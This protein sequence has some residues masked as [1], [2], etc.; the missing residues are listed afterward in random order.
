MSNTHQNAA[1]LADEEAGL[2]A[3]R[4]TESNKLFHK[5]N[6]SFSAKHDLEGTKDTTR[7]ISEVNSN[8]IQKSSYGI[9]AIEAYTPNFAISA[10]TLD[11]QQIFAKRDQGQETIAVWDSQE[12]SISMA[13]NAVT[14]LLEKHISDPYSIGR[15][16]VGTE[17]NVDMAKSI[18][19]YLMDLFPPDHV[20]MEGVDNIN[21]SYGA[22]AALLN[23][24]SWCRETGGFGI[25]V[26][27]DTADMDLNDSAW[28][29]ASA[30]AM[31]V[32][33]NPW[34]E[35]HPERT[36]YFKNT[37]DFLLPRHASQITPLINT[38]D[39][40]NHYIDALAACIKSMDKKFSI[41]SRRFDAFIF[42]GGLCATFM[43]LVER[44]LMR[45]NSSPEHWDA[46]FEHARSFATQIGGQYNSSLYVNL[47]SLLHGNSEI[48]QDATLNKIGMFAYGAGSTAT[49]MRATIHPD[50]SHNID[51]ATMIHQRKRVSFATL[52]T[53]V[54]SHEKNDG[55]KFLARNK[56]IYYRDTSISQVQTSRRVYYRESTTETLVP[57]LADL[58]STNAIT[59]V[60]KTPN[61]S[62]T[63]RSNVRLAV[64]SDMDSILK[65]MHSRSD[66]M[67]PR[68]SEFLVESIKAETAVLRTD[69]VPAPDN[70]SDFF[71]DVLL[72]DEE[73]IRTFIWDEFQ[74]PF[75]YQKGDVVVYFGGLVSKPGSNDSWFMVIEEWISSRRAE[76]IQKAYANGSRVIFSY[77]ILAGN[78]RK[79]TAIHKVA[80]E[81]VKA[82]LGGDHIPIHDTITPSS[83]GSGRNGFMVNIFA[84]PPMT[85]F[86]STRLSRNL[87]LISDSEQRHLLHSRVGFIGLSTG[88][89]VLEVFLREGIGGTYRLAD[90]DIFEM[91]NANRM[92]YGINDIGKPK[93]D[94]CTERIGSVDPSIHVEKFS[95]GVTAE[96]LKEFVRDCDLIIEECDSFPI[97]VLVRAEA[98]SQRVPLLMGTS[99][100]GMID[101]ERYDLDPNTPSP[102]LNLDLESTD[103]NELLSQ[104][105]DLNQWGP[106][107]LHSLKE[108]GSTIESWPQLAEEV[109]LNAA[110]IAHAAR[111]IL[112][113]DDTVISGR[114]SIRLDQLFEPG[115]RIKASTEA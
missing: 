9:I 26:A 88:S 100:N 6:Y 40:M 62:R 21:S 103:R 29:G 85:S 44:Y 50:R 53:I 3:N 72:E 54:M 51:L 67:K 107:M 22:T 33:K 84:D 59:M 16:E 36:S 8:S 109:T 56:G 58:R 60:N 10:D 30:V 78:E 15:I 65:L 2:I 83:D 82:A 112:L 69:E 99:Q 42:H 63:N 34:I 79:K 32:G 46:H 7:L 41:D 12:D 89:V 90:H 70:V 108:I 102:F 110:T 13:M 49:L 74:F 61:R 55:V 28:R 27:T 73:K 87:Y 31:L 25:V 92:L 17:S 97:K 91:S 95:S 47:L 71:L 35:I 45:L 64:S 77:G 39:S 4:I 80:L 101:V 98:K 23:T 1:D 96:N 43:K 115:N 113:G 24:I 104:V 38:K 18:K 86:Q 11:R 19:S 106:R 111:R 52:T 14:K 5:N 48:N 93:V 94:I 66:A 76:V 68:S 105:I 81:W 20:D 57:I 37:H 75:R 114:F